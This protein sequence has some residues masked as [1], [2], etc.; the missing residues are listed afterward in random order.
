MAGTL[1]HERAMV[2][3]L[4]S[5]Q[6]QPAAINQYVTV[7]GQHIVT[8]A[9]YGISGCTLPPQSGG[10]CVTALWT[11]AATRV[12]ASGQPV[13]FKDSLATC[14]PTGANVNIISTQMWVTVT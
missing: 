1:L 13:L 6:A 14:T 3:C 9:P 11:S 7:G 12:T 5:G 10:P 2:Q 8:L 4:H